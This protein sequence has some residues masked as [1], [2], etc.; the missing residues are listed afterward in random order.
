MN[1]NNMN[2]KNQIIL[3]FFN[4]LKIF[5]HAKRGN[6]PVNFKVSNSTNYFLKILRK[7][8][9]NNNNKM[10]QIKLICSTSLTKKIIA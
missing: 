2:N 4:F 5:L 8:N 6:H 7:I 3:K 9:N 10:L 1:I